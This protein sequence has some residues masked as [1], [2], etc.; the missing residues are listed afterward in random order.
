MGNVNLKFALCKVTW[1]KKIGGQTASAGLLFDASYKL[2]RKLHQ[3]GNLPE[4]ALDEEGENV[5]V[6]QRWRQH[7][8]DDTMKKLPPT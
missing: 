6:R 1:R 7:N 2:R 8:A 5:D 4:V 3:T